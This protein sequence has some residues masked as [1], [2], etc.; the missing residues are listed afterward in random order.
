MMTPAAPEEV[1]AASEWSKA[2]AGGM[3]LISR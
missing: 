3:G 2:H 1:G